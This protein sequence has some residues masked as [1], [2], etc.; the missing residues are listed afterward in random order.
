M[1]EFKFEFE[2]QAGGEDHHRF[3]Q[4]R[5]EKEIRMN[6]QADRP[7]F[8]VSLPSECLN[9]DFRF[10]LEAIRALN[11]CDDPDTN[12]DDLEE[13][14]PLL[15]HAEHNDI[16]AEDGQLKRK[17]QKG[18]WLLALE[19]SEGGTKLEIVDRG[20]VNVLVNELEVVSVVQWEKM[21]VSGALVKEDGRLR[22]FFGQNKDNNIKCANKRKRDV[23]KPHVKADEGIRMNISSTY[24]RTRDD[25]VFW[26]E[27][28]KDRI[29][30][31]APEEL[32][33]DFFRRMEQLQKNKT[34]NKTSD[35]PEK[36]PYLFH[37]C[38]LRARLII[39]GRE[40]IAD[41]E[42]DLLNS[43]EPLTKKGLEIKSMEHYH[44][45]S[46]G[47]NDK[48]FITVSKT[49]RGGHYSAEI[50]DEDSGD[51]LSTHPVVISGYVRIS[52]LY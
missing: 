49:I 37:M 38:R 12:N 17:M 14:S 31:K 6:K 39:E 35:E 52:I 21:D 43:G 47:N 34:K 32:R 24:Q 42:F 30:K 7:K 4:F 26:D 33:S 44:Y 15:I 46:K 2:G 16:R 5:D 45:C 36:D 22:I 29:A 1:N 51:V 13:F 11:T 19:G 50:E 40:T 9:N 25:N 41:T 48:A 3:H 23:V 10:E 28:V 8:A 20:V 18:D 27:V